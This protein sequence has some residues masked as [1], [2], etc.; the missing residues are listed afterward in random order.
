MESQTLGGTTTISSR[1]RA[2]GQGFL[3][4]LWVDVSTIKNVPKSCPTFVIK[5]LFLTQVIMP[6]IESGKLHIFCLKRYLLFL[7]LFQFSVALTWL[8]SLWTYL[9]SH[10]QRQSS[11]ALVAREPN[12]CIRWRFHILSPKKT[13]HNRF[14]KIYLSSKKKS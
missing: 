14:Q 5:K 9:L 6:E 1:C 11:A 13:S 10:F 4:H 12:H 2:S 8:E 3:I 7:H